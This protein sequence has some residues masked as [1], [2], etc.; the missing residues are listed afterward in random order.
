MQSPVV[1]GS[2]SS[3][4][5]FPVARQWTVG[6]LTRR[7]EDRPVKLP[8]QALVSIMYISSLGSST[9]LRPE[10][11]EEY[12]LHRIGTWLQR[13]SPSFML[14]SHWLQHPGDWS[15]ATFIADPMHVAKTGRSTWSTR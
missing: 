12:E 13:D 5:W 15:R 1:I 14:F 3:A 7:T 9:S 6:L 2:L 11:L 10:D 4:P 8:L